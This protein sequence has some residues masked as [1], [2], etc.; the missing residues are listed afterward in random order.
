[1][2][3]RAMRNRLAPV[4]AMGTVKCARC[5]ELIE[6]GSSGSSPPRR[7]P[8]LPRPLARGLQRAS[9]LGEDGGANGNGAF[10]DEVPGRWSRRC[11]QDPPVGTEVF[12]GNGLM[13]MHVGRGVWQ[14]VC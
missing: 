4:V 5:D 13:E 2:A 7:R 9:W 14:T 6:P 12:L 8:G 10:C 11:Y 3:H 1:M